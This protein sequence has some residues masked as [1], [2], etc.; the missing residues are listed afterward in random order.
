MKALGVGSDMRKAR[1]A[2]DAKSGNGGTAAEVSEV[3]EGLARIR[4]EALSAQFNR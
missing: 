1:P 2:R 3:I 4:A